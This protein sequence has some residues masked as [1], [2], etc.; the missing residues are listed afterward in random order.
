[1]LA[2]SPAVALLIDRARRTNPGFALSAANASALV[3]ACVRLD[4]LPLAIELAGD[5]AEG[6]D[7]ARAGGPVSMRM[8]LLEST[9]RDVPQRQRALRTAVTWSHDLLS[10]EERT[11]F[12]R[13]SVFAGAWT[14]ADAAAVCGDGASDQLSLVES[15]LDK[16]MASGAPAMRRPRSSP[17]W[18]A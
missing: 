11:L 14:I 18:K 17:C 9:A 10:P 7:A 8:S 2:A 4:G 13:L 15:L 6:S 1:M 5:T 12:R 3:E 16:N